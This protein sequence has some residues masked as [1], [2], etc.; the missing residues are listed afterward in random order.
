MRKFLFS[1]LL[2]VLRAAGGMQGQENLRN[3]Y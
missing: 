1:S 2:V 3:Y